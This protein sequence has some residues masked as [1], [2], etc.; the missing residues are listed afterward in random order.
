MKRDKIKN[1][2]TSIKDKIFDHLSSDGPGGAKIIDAFM[3]EFEELEDRAPKDDPTNLSNHREFLRNHIMKTWDSSLSVDD[4]GNVSIGICSDDVLGFD[5]D[6]S[7]LKHKPSPVVWT[8]YLIRGIGG[9][10]AFVSPETYFK[11]FGKPMPP[12]YAGGFLISSNVWQNEN[13]DD[14]VGSFESYE[15]PSS[16]ASPIPFFR[17]VI[18]RIDI[19]SIINEAIEDA[20]LEVKYETN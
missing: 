2:F 14:Y 13:W 6:S 10:Y 19:D 8:V 20:R 12:Q 16:G 9:R 17:N 3:E 4:N 15:H 7:K 5:V 11:R 1:V 18:S